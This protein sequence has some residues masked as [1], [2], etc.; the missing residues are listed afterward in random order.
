MRRG[1]RKE[2]IGDSQSGKFEYGCRA[3]GVFHSS[4]IRDKA[5]DLSILGN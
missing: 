4:G 1:V 2:S 5:V 3:V